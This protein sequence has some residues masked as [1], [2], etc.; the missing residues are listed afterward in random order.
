M[1]TKKAGISEI[2][3]WLRKRHSSIFYSLIKEDCLYVEQDWLKVYVSFFG[4]TIGK[5]SEKYSALIKTRATTSQE[6][7]VLQR[8]KPFVC[9]KS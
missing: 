9:D 3:I 8:E 5:D 2:T 6:I 1:I 7:I 4:D